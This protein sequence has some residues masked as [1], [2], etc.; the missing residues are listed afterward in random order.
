MFIYRYQLCDVKWNAS[1]SERFGVSNGVRQGAVSSPLLFSV[2]IDGLLS[3]LRKCGLGCKID[4]HY[5][6][7]LGYA[8]DLLLLSASRSGLQAMVSVCE[9]FTK[10]R[11]LK[12]STNVNPAKSKTKCVVFTKEKN[13]KDR[14]APIILDGNPL[15]WVNSV[16]H[17]GHILESDNSMK[18]DCL[19][20]R[21]KFIGKVHSLLQEFSYVD[22]TV[23]ARILTIYVTSFY[24]SNLWNLYSSEVT[25]LFS[26]WNVTI[27]NVFNLPWT[28]HRFFIEEVSG[29]PHPKTMLCTRVVKFWETLRSCKKNSVRFLANLVYNDKK[30]LTGK[31]VSNIAMDCRVERGELSRVTVK[32]IRYFPPL[33]EDEWKVKLLRELLDIRDGRAAVPGLGYE[34]ITA[35][36]TEICCN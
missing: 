12:F 23:L 29:T 28:T 36:I 9:K 25:K 19:A 2:Y 8:D 24:G 31:T 1:N 32:N 26:S 16:N 17:L 33:P 11:K 20:K 6:G 15:P 34:E 3:L 14:L 4:H 30:T 35:M 13:L 10:K 21:G 5:Y 22:S 18:S 7:V 27:R